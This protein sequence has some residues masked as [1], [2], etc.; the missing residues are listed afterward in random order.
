MK[1]FSYGKDGGPESTVWSFTLVE[2]KSLFSIVLLKFVGRSRESYHTHAFNAISWVLKGGLFEYT[3]RNPVSS[4][5]RN[6]PTSFRPIITKRDTFHK[7]HSDGVTWALSFRGPWSKTWTEYREKEGTTVT[8]ASGR[9][10][11]NASHTH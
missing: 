5:L 9:K 11:I 10:E 7:V 8:L 4:A 1:L 3:R 2:I 6:Y